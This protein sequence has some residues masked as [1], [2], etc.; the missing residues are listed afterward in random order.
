VIDDKACVDRDAVVVDSIVMSGACVGAGAVV[1]NSIIGWG[2]TVA[3]AASV[4]DLTVIGSDEQIEPG[5]SLERGVVPPPESW[6]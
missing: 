1:R 2:S 4:I 5:A 6:A 3:A